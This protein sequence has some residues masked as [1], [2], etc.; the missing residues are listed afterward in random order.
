[1]VSPIR[2]AAY[3]EF[4]SVTSVLC[5][6]VSSLAALVVMP[7]RR[8]PWVVKL[9]FS[10]TQK[11]WF[12]LDFPSIA[13]YRRQKADCSPVALYDP[14]LLKHCRTGEAIE[15]AEKL[16]QKS[17]SESNVPFGYRKRRI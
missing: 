5:I 12:D 9:G 17:K 15:V 10:I 11:T 2:A 14:R 7:T 13:L 16:V 8:S 6:V 3:D 1:M 4:T